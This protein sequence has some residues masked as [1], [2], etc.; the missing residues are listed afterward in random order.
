M[1]YGDRWCLHL[2]WWAL[3]NVQTCQ[4]ISCT[5]ETYVTL[6]INC[7]SIKKW[8]I[9]LLTSTLPISFYC[10]SKWP[11]EHFPLCVVYICGVHY[12]STWLCCSGQA[13]LQKLPS[14][15]T[16]H[17]RSMLGVV[18][19]ATREGS[20]GGR[21]KRIYLMANSRGEPSAGCSGWVWGWEQMKWRT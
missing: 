4:I 6:Y 8:D 5:P 7:T 21:V 15:P 19:G 12:I 17:S 1:S 16:F 2:P 11:L 14:M 10:L 3:S 9:V 18:P 20:G 13:A